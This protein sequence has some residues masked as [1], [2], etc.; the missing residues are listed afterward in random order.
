[1]LRFAP[2]I[3]AASLA[4]HP[5]P[6]AAAPL[7]PTGKWVMDYTPTACEAKRRFGDVAIAIIPGALGQSTRLMVELPGKAMRARQHRASIDPEDGRGAAK[8]TALLFPLKRPGARGLY[9]VLP[10]ELVDRAMA[11]G[12][13]TIR[14]GNEVMTGRVALN[15]AFT[16][17]ALGPMASLRKALDTCMDDLRKTWGMVDGKLPTPANASQAKGDV[18]GIFTS[19]DYP[20]DA[21]TANQSGITRYLLMI[22][23]DGSVMDCVVAESSGIASLDAMGCQVIRERAKFRP[24]TDAH[25]KPTV[26]TYSTPPIRWAISG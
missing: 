25:G 21:L 16:Q 3:A 18:R 9:F 24:A 2:I 7:Q 12:S 6:L 10:N 15:S 23:R 26:D 20:D 17:L 22:G 11:S 8:A 1:M 13:I 4:I 19:D 14:V 5:S